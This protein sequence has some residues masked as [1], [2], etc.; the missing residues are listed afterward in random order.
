MRVLEGTALLA[1]FY[2]WF[3]TVVAVHLRDSGIRVATWGAV[4]AGGAIFTALIALNVARRIDRDQRFRRWVTAGAGAYALG[5]LFLLPA[6]LPTVIVGVAF[7]GFAQVVL[8]PLESSLTARLAPKGRTGEYQGAL[9]VVYAAAFATGPVLGLALY[10]ATSAQFT[11]LFAVSVLPL[12]ATLVS[13]AIAGATAHGRLS[14]TKPSRPKKVVAMEGLSY[15]VGERRVQCQRAIDDAEKDLR[16]L[17]RRI[18]AA[19]EDSTRVRFGL[20]WLLTP[21]G[22]LGMIAAAVHQSKVIGGGEPFRAGVFVAVMT[23]GVLLVLIGV[24]YEWYSAQRHRQQ[25]E[26]RLKDLRKDETEARRRLADAR[27]QLDELLSEPLTAARG[28]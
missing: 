5:F 27:S 13:A 16:R 1:L 21:V 19:N 8:N 11:F 3:D 15:L 7:V 28:R 17:D 25:I 18:R 10:Q 9:S 12:G 6:W 2:G 23:A 20:G 14:L 24:V 22:L 4:Y 26:L